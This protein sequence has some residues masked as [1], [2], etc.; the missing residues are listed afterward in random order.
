MNVRI[1]IRSSV[2]VNAQITW[3]RSLADLDAMRFVAAMG[4]VLLHF[5]FVVSPGLGARLVGLQALVDSFFVISGVVM[6]H[7]YGRRLTSESEGW[8]YFMA[9]MGRIMPLHLATLSFYV[10]VGLS[11]LVTDP[12]RYDWGCLPAT[13]FLFQSAG[14]CDGL[15]FNEVSWSISAEMLMYAAFPF[16]LIVWRRAP[17][18]PGVA[19]SGIV[20]VLTVVDP[21]WWGRTFD[22]GYLRAIPAFMIGMSLYRLR[23][24][25][26]RPSLWLLAT[27]AAFA[28]AVWLQ[29]GLAGVL[30]SYALVAAGM[31]TRSRTADRMA[32]LGALTYSIYMLHPLVMTLMFTGLGRRVLDLGPVGTAVLVL[33]GVPLLIGLSWASLR[34]FETP[35]REWVKRWGARLPGLAPSRDPAWPPGHGGEADGPGF[36][37]DHLK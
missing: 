8:T 28:A 25:L 4:I 36:K 9:R 21:G 32:P 5:S 7:A 31:A 14:V 22:H 6:C 30:L 3:G 37:L 15:T 27:T 35:A 16:L 29:N 20:L 12:A 10:V 24:R 17:W 13:L 2:P 19:G 18:L 26:G 1:S 23:G 33:S 11:G 34:F